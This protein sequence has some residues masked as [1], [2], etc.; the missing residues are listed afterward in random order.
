MISSECF[1]RDEKLNS[2]FAENKLSEFVE[3]LK[4]LT[5]F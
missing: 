4:R 5:R 2:I 1:N 3:K